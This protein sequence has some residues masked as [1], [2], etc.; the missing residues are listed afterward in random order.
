M[1]KVSDGIETLIGEGDWKGARKAIRAELRTEPESHWLLACLA[2]TYYEEFKYGKALEY[3]T[4]ALALAPNCPLTLW[5]YAGALDMLGRE[6]EALKIYRRLVRRGAES[7]AYGECGEGLARA[8]GLVVDCLYRMAG[9]YKSLGDS[10]KAAE[11]LERHLARRGKG[12]HSIYPLGEV[13]KEL[14]EL[15]HGARP[16]NG[17]I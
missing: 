6:R 17:A 2:L 11:L 14:R 4:R 9:C 7:I 8:R 16:S 1:S 12:C 13:R 5:G 10:R 15:R 3:E